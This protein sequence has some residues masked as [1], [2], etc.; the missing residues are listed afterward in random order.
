[1]QRRLCSAIL[2]LEA[3]VL[4]L[5]SLVLVNVSHLAP[6]VSLG[7]GL[8]LCVACLVVA[9]LLRFRWAIA[10]GWLIQLAAIALAVETL[11][12]GVLGVIFLALWATAVRLGARIERDRADWAAASAEP[13]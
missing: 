2:T 3:I 9:G 5:S 13:R 4:G 8:G 10:L 7:L 12:L 6:G 11:A 1:M